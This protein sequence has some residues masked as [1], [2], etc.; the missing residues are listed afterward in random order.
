MAHRF[1]TQYVETARDQKMEVKNAKG[2]RGR[3][4][5]G[6]VEFFGSGHTTRIRNKYTLK[7]NCHE[8]PPTVRP[9]RAN[10]FIYY[11]INRN[12]IPKSSAV[13]TKTSLLTYS[14]LAA[15]RSS[16]SS[17]TCGPFP[18]VRTSWW[19]LAR[20]TI[21]G[22]KS[23]LALS[24]FS[25]VSRSPRRWRA[26]PP[27]AITMRS[28]AGRV[29][30]YERRGSCDVDADDDDAEA[31]DDDDDDDA[32]A[33]ARSSKQDAVFRREHRPWEIMMARCYYYL[34]WC[35]YE[36]YGSHARCM[37]LSVFRCQG[38]RE[39]TSWRR[40]PP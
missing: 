38:R 5:R 16:A 31:D 4:A 11:I 27:T 2:R 18:C 26:F 35:F 6:G 12:A 24:M 40:G 37:L 17:P 28:H 19:S 34:Y 30:E 14:Y 20:D 22:A 29:V 13:S 10:E 9:P 1:C 25:I 7:S 39:F 15:L 23:A 21:V 3:T 32:A 8:K 36:E 33:A